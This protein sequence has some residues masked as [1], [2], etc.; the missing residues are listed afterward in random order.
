MMYIDVDIE[1]A[2]LESQEFNDCKDNICMTSSVRQGHESNDT[3]GILT[4]DVA[5]TASLALLCVM[6]S[7]GPI[8][9]NVA[10]LTVEPGCT[11]HG[12]ASTDTAEL[13]QAIKHGAVVAH[14]VFSLFPHVVVHIVRGHLLEKVDVLVGVKLGHLGKDCRL[15]A[16]V[17]RDRLAMDSTG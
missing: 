15:R 16:L 10:F 4:V 13:E 2:L 3:Y 6:K 1:D 12:A 11:L 5:E 17:T 9:S 7:T 14:V 8:D